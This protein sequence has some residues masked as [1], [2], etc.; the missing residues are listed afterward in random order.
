MITQDSAF[1]YA[2]VVPLPPQLVAGVLGQHQA[3]GRALGLTF[4]HLVSS[5][6]AQ[7]QTVYE[8]KKNIL[9]V[10]TSVDM[11]KMLSG[12]SPR[13]KHPSRPKF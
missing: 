5:L 8:M 1:S 6:V 3:A 13:K 2:C 11:E 9:W 7:L 10:Y 12:K 4:L